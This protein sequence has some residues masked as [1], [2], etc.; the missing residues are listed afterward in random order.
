MEHRRRSETGASEPV[1][2]VVGFH[3]EGQSRSP[4]PVSTLNEHSKNFIGGS[5]TP[6]IIPPS[7]QQ[8]SES[9]N[10]HTSQLEG[11]IRNQTDSSSSQSQTQS[12]TNSNSATPSPTHGA[13]SSQTSAQV[14][15]SGPVEP[16]PFRTSVATKS[17]SDG[18]STQ[19]T[20]AGAPSSNSANLSSAV[21]Q[22][23][24]Y[25]KHAAP[26][27]VAPEPHPPPQSTS[28]KSEKGRQPPDKDKDAKAKPATRAERRALQESQRA[29]K[30]AA[31]ADKQ[32]PAKAAVSASSGGE[33]RSSSA[34]RGA[35]EARTQ[36]PNSTAAADK[37]GRGPAVETSQA[38]HGAVKSITEEKKEKKKE[39]VVS[40]NSTELFAHLQQYKAVSVQSVL[41]QRDA[42]KVHPAILQLG[43]RYADGSIVGSNA[44]CVAMLN[45]FCQVIRDYSTPEGKSLSRDLT[46][47]LN[48]N[49]N[50]LVECRPLS[51]SMGNAIK[52]VKLFTSKIDPSMPEESAKAELL[53]L[54]HDFISLR[55]EAADNFLVNNAV[56]KI[57]DGDV[58]LTY[59]YSH[60]VASSLMAAH[61]LGRRFK[62]VVMDSRPELEG[63]KMLRSLLK[64]GISCSYVYITG[65][66][67]IMREVTKVFLG[68]A[69]VL[70]NGTVISRAGSAA[71]AMMASANGTPVMICCETYKFHERVQLDSITNN[72]L[73]N[74]AAL[75][76]VPGR[77]DVN[78]LQHA[79]DNVRL[80][81]LNLKYDAMPAEYVTL[82]VTE[83][84]MIPPT[85]VPVILREYRNE[86]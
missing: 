39:K 2:Q 43:L 7:F 36:K 46:S 40:L 41:T 80:G 20:S 54:I 56:T 12:R 5:P 85:S 38:Q 70:S 24:D 69:S 64:A 10:K 59:A 50:F 57:Y 72:E 86:V 18:G 68:A 71:V 78:A 44:R 33:S 31:Q 51:I 74:P 60:V 79:Q 35:G 52:F 66:S 55:I 6:V 9:L 34:P 73:G 8:R 23:S 29:A 1:V 30:A 82:I 58:I 84:G 11:L 47:Q 37:G 21:S 13:A 49:V 67:Y 22:L 4:I 14:G 61:N 26:P 25:P 83:L 17:A 32:P 15:T 16:E 28:D 53:S 45:A 77:P 42:D 62:V 65:L 27:A 63:R 3:V 81:L 75:L 76:T 48:S 19:Q